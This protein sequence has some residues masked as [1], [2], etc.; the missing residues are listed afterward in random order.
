MVRSGFR[1]HAYVEQPNLVYVSPGV[2]VVE[3][4]NEP[5]FWYGDYYWAY[6][7]GLWYRSS[8]YSGG[9][10]RVHA[11]PAHIRGIH[12]PY[13]YRHYRA[14]RGVRTRPAP[15]VRD[16]RTYQPRGRDNRTYQ[17][18]RN[19][20]V[21]ARRAQPPSHGNRGVPPTYRGGT[22]THKNAPPPRR[23]PTKS[24]SKPKPKKSKTRSHR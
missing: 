9:W 21:P 23:K 19:E 13:R 12:N 14:P 3:D 16:H 2:W 17:P 15:G 5:V 24:R 11:A 22:R 6:R 7:N 20:R 8:V 4:Y 10:V 1:T 18:R